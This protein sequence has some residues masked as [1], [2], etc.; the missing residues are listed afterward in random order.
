M[1]SAIAET[2]RTRARARIHDTARALGGLYGYA[3]FLFPVAVKLFYK[4]WQQSFIARE[5]LVYKTEITGKSLCSTRR[6][7]IR[8]LSVLAVFP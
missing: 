8:G 5:T 2:Q 4:R 3:K 7:D 6:G 1:A